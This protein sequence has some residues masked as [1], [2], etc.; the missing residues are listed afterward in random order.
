MEEITGY[1]ESIRY[2]NEDNGYTV[3]DFVVS[4]D[5]ITCVGNFIAINEG[6]NLCLKGE[7]ID[8]K[9]YGK[10]LKVI[11][12]EMVIPG[13]AEAIERYLGSG[14]ISGIGPALAAR[15]V[16]KFGDDTIEIIENQPERLAEVKGI[17]L[18]KAID[19]SEQIADN[20]AARAAM[21]YMEKYGIH[22]ALAIRIYNRF[23]AMLYEI[24]QNNPYKLADEIE[25]IGFVKADEIARKIGIRV[26]SE[27]RIRSGIE[28]VIMNGAMQGHTYIPKDQTISIA[29]SLL[30]VEDKEI[31][32]QLQNMIS[33]RRIIAIDKGDTKSSSVQI[34][35]RSFYKKEND[36]AIMLKEIDSGIKKSSSSILGL[37]SQI[38]EEEK[39]E[40]DELQKLAVEKAYNSGVFILTGGPGTGKTTTIKTMIRLF[41]KRGLSICLA[42]PTGRA[43]KRMCEACGWEAKTIHRLLEV[44][45]SGD[46]DE[47]LG[48][49]EK[50]NENPLE[51][52]V[53]IIDESS[54]VDVNL[55]HALLSAIAPG[56]RLILVGDEHQLPSVG[57]GNILCDIIKSEKYTSVTL[58]K[59]FRQ[60]QTSKIVVNAHRIQQGVQVNLEEKSDDFYFVKK[61]TADS[62]REA[63]VEL[64]SKNLPNHFGIQQQEIQVLSPTKQGLV[65]VKELNKYLQDKLNPKSEEKGFYESDVRSFR[66][67]DKVMQIKNNYELEW[68][69][70]G[71]YNIVV[72]N[73]KGVFNGDVGFVVD[74]DNYMKTLTV[75][76]DDN[77][78]VEYPFTMLDEI[79][80]AYAVTVHKSQGSEYPVVIIPLLQG[81]KMLMNRNI[82]YTALTRAK[83]C[84]VFLG[85]KEV[86]YSMANDTTVTKRYSGLMDRIVEL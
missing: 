8:H 6:E 56:T 47:G 44:K 20:K 19:I 1:V 5:T 57:P 13:D 15:I 85:D 21:I 74:V 3:L 82:L 81:P 39:I 38:E 10:Q 37:I 43:A 65:G 83:E 17:S 26:D 22:G 58:E 16:D 78:K 4:K 14:V 64:I 60:A 49:F 30:H 35:L 77:R 54:M 68:S 34:Y 27:F 32:D 70:V 28:Y 67:G 63:I 18:K 73:G 11:S 50:N 41:E 69:I 46:D 24:F 7:Y 61:S 36:I 29:K 59:I 86:F 12:Y 84:V 48:S 23:G 72:D 80:L 51:Y 33:E 45:V 66:V 53:I 9:L 25:G 52:D 71:K 62:V 75:E 2:R 42:A 31:E 40:L 55:M 76:Y 79:E